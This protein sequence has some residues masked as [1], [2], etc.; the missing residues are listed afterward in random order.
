MD[1]GLSD[2]EIGIFKKLSTPEKIQDFLDRLAI[3]YEKGGE[4]HQSPRRVLKSRRAHC[5][6]GALLAAAAL[7]FHGEKPLLLDLS[8]AKGDD[9]HVIALFQLN[10]YWGAISKTNHASLRWRDPIYKDLRELALSYFHE[11]FRDTDGKK[12]LRGYSKPLDMRRFG[13][14]W[15]TTGEELWRIDRAL[16]A[17][18][19]EDL[20]PKKNRRFLRNAGPFERKAGRLREWKKTDRRT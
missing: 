12:M 15:I 20:I 19:H 5:I 4:T 6:E 7:W 8:S 10:G 13:T 16:N 2:S 9:D 14:D 1:F 17:L 18:P 3:N 11:W